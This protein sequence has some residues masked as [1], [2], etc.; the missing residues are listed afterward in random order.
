VYATAEA[1]KTMKSFPIPKQFRNVLEPGGPTAGITS[2][3]TIRCT[4]QGGEK[5]LIAWSILRK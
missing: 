1:W 5:F 2:E 3:E 4:F